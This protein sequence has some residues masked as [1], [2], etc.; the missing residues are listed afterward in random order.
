MRGGE[1]E[2]G[3]EAIHLQK[4]VDNKASDLME[5][6]VSRDICKRGVISGELKEKK[7]DKGKRLKNIMLETA[8]K[9]ETR[10]REEKSRGGGQIN[11]GASPLK[12]RGG[13]KKKEN[14]VFRQ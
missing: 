11:R 8:I 10:S 2:E 9:G 6:K 1:E 4:G 3:R 5:E 13:E 14:R 7:G 12:K